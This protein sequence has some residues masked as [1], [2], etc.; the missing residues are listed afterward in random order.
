MPRNWTNCPLSGALV[1]K[2]G[3]ETALPCSP[4]AS[5]QAPDPLGGVGPWTRRNDSGRTRAEF[6]IFAASIVCH[7]TLLELSAP[8]RFNAG[9]GAREARSYV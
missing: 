5:Y 4:R 3:V 9:R 1:G 8:P 6:L 2:D 7:C